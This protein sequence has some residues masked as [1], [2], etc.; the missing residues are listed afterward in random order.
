VTD[1]FNLPRE[2]RDSIYDCALPEAKWRITLSKDLAVL[3][4]NRQMR[5]ETL[6]LAYRRTSFRLD[7]MDDL[8]KLLISVGQIGRNEIESLEFPWESRADSECKWDAFPDSD[9]HFLMLPTLHVTRCVQ[10]LKHCKRLKLL[11][12]LF[13]SELILKMPHSSFK[14]D[15]GIRRLCSIQGIKRVEILSLAYEPLKDCCLAKWLK[16]EIEGSSEGRRS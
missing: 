7:D 11:R 1:F 12:I 8:I 6:P 2:V 5:E 16:D 4:V 14:A 9:D 15:P 10:L 13:E 3:R